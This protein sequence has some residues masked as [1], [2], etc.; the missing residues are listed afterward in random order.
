MKARSKL[1]G[2][3]MGVIAACS[4]A[5][6]LLAADTPPAQSNDN[7]SLND[8][9]KDFKDKLANE[10]F[11]K[12]EEMIPMR[13]GI[14]L[15]TIILLPKGV[16]GAPMVLTRTPYDVAERAQRSVSGSLRTKTLCARVTFESG[17][18][19]AASTARKATSS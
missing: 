7:V 1:L 19:F 6:S 14:K 13:D 18:T 11:I 16:Q 8:I 5:A 17:K 4:F 9:P 3:G 10:D 2:L 12:R 15:K